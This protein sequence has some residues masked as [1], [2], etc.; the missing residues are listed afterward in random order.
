MYYNNN[1]PYYNYN[2]YNRKY[3]Y[4]NNNRTG[5]FI[6]PFALG[7]LSAP[8]LLKPNYQPYYP[9]QNYPNYSYYY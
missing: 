4:R 8:L 2:M 9:Y 7:F 1:I 3:N 5:G 6:F